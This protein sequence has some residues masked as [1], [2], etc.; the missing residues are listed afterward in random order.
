MQTYFEILNEYFKQQCV[1]LLDQGLD[2]TFV[3]EFVFKFT[4]IALV[5]DVV[6]FLQQMADFKQ[7]EVSVSYKADK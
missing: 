2:K 3:E 7:H 1:P 6:N 4:L 5:L